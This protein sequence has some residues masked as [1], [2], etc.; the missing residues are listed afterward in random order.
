MLPGAPV[1]RGFGVGFGWASISALVSS[2]GTAENAFAVAGKGGRS[3]VLW[4]GVTARP[5]AGRQSS[6]WVW[7]AGTICLVKLSKSKEQLAMC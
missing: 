5:A 2:T 7:G 4:K 3:A 1:P 6:A